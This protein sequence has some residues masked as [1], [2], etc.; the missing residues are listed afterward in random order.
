MDVPTQVSLVS[1]LQRIN[2]VNGSAVCCCA[3]LQGSAD[4]TKVVLEDFVLTFIL[5]SQKPSK[6]FNLESSAGGSAK[7]CIE[8]SNRII[9]KLTN[10]PE[11]Y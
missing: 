8:S 1:T 3:V 6:I 10:A 2:R 5:K 11:T 9:G 4:F 7:K